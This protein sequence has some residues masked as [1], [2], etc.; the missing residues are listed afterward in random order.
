MSNF[1]RLQFF[2]FVAGRA[3]CPQQTEHDGHEQQCGQRSNHQ[4]ADDRAT[5][6]SVLFA[7]FAEP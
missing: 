6:R 7:A 3:F 5:K 1:G 4:T 2:F